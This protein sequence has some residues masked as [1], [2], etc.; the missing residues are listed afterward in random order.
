MREY[1]PR[2]QPVLS[3]LYSTK[4]RACNLREEIWI[5]DK[6]YAKEIQD[7]WKSYVIITVHYHETY[8]RSQDNLK[9]ELVDAAN[10]RYIRP[11]TPGT[12]RRYC[13]NPF[14]NTAIE[15]SGKSTLLLFPRREWMCVRCKRTCKSRTCSKCRT[16]RSCEAWNWK[17]NPEYF[18]ELAMV[19]QMTRD[20]AQ[21]WSS[22]GMRDRGR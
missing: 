14:H 10:L 16:D 1:P 11:E 13:D 4:M 2:A 6:E 17:T 18:P 12:E 5:Q 9:K 7:E 19:L 21:S 15:A 22:G 3:K 8:T 20:S